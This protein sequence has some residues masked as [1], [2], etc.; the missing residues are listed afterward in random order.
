M[1]EKEL[2][3]IYYARGILRNKMQYDER[4]DKMVLQLLEKL[5]ESGMPMET[6]IRSCKNTKKNLIEFIKYCDEYIIKRNPDYRPM[7][8]D[9]IDYGLEQ[10]P[11]QS[12]IVKP[13]INPKRVG[14]NIVV[15]S[16]KLAE[17]RLPIPKS[18]LKLLMFVASL[19]HPSDDEF[20]TYILKKQ[21]VLEAL[22]MGKD[23]QSAL[24]RHIKALFDLSVEIIF[25]N[26][27]WSLSHILDRADYKFKEE[28]I[29]LRLHV[30]MRKLLLQQRKNFT[31]A[32]LK[33]FL[34]LT[35]EYSLEIYKRMKTEYGKHQRHSPA[36]YWT[37]TV[38]ALKQYLGIPE[39]KYELYGHFKDRVLKFAQD[40]LR[41]KTDIKFEFEERK[42]ARKVYELG[43][44]ITHNPK[45]LDKQDIFKTDTD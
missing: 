9:F 36:V 10:S 11:F 16:N 1:A 26:G 12:E 39:G 6:I 28:E 21:A 8:P 40:E 14:N 23:N 24:K 45:N 27:D 32:E 4:Y 13:V 41:E 18:S 38:E 44:I 34:G 43:F 5:Q 2:N 7:F 17:V 25:D 35:G 30:D 29:H 31:E 3:N 42:R 33:N 20:K 19:I 22:G 15:Y 37:I